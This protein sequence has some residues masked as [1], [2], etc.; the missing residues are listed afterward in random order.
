M[1]Y[2][3]ERDETNENVP[4]FFGCQQQKNI[5][6]ILMEYFPKDWDKLVY[7]SALP[8]EVSGK[9]KIFQ[10]LV[11]KTQFMHNN[12]VLHC[13]LKA[14]NIYSQENLSDFRLGDFGFARRKGKDL[15]F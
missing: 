9:A 2:L 4:K 1:A 6:K 7:K 8:K 13:D 11:K 5:L 3:S 14:E 10:G 15:P 12:G